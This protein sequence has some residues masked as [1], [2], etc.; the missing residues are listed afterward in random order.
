MTG[1]ERIAQGDRKG[2]M[3]QGGMN[4]DTC[5]EN[6]KNFKS[7][8]IGDGK[9]VLYMVLYYKGGIALSQLEKLLEKIKNNPKG[10]R[11]G[12]LDKLLVR[13]GFQKRQPRKGSSHYTYTKGSIRITVP[14]QQPH[15]GET[16]VK[17]AI[18]ALEGE[19][20]ND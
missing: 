5:Q 20:N 15:I 6:T 17:L 18:K 2:E 11:F 14:F 13:S 12:E 4:A 1:G 10:V 8:E 19:I 16:Y 7:S 3:A 9:L